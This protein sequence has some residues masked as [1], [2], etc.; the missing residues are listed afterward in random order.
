ML[1]F[2]DSSVKDK[3]ILV[4]LFIIGIRKFKWLPHK[5]IEIFTI[6][7]WT[8]TLI[9]STE[10]EPFYWFP[11]KILDKTIA[12]NVLR[13]TAFFILKVSE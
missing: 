9:W 3:A 4:D 1:F 6:L 5:T 11:L 13:T 7:C 10:S 8:V 12:N 2:C